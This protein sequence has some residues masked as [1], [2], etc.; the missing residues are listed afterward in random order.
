MKITNIKISSS[1]LTTPDTIDCF[2]QVT[3]DLLSKQKKVKY[4]DQV[5]N[6]KYKMFCKTEEGMEKARAREVRNI[7]SQLN[8]KSDFAP[9]AVC[10]I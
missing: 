3:Q 7:R 6:S 4:L 1:L 8:H 9:D 5:K 10:F 2:S